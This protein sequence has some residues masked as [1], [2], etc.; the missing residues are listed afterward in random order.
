MIEKVKSTTFNSDTI[1]SM[2]NTIINRKFYNKLNI[3]SL[4]ILYY[5][6]Y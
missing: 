5:L 1:S 4:S 3:L 2:T 6:Y